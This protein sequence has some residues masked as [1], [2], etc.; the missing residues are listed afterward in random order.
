MASSRESS[1]MNSN[2]SS[3]KAL[4]E[5]EWT[6]ALAELDRVPGQNQMEDSPII[7]AIMKDARRG[8]E[9]GR[10]QLEETGR[11]LQEA[12]PPPPPTP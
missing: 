8:A 6:A 3:T 11:T 4:T 9:A 10:R 7:V 5:A 12:P 1:L 2:A